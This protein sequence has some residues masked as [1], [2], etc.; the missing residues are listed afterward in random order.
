MLSQPPVAV[1]A[2]WIK[3]TGQTLIAM[4]FVLRFDMF[5]TVN[6]YIWPCQTQEK[7][8]K[9]VWRDDEWSFHLTRLMWYRNTII[10][11]KATSNNS[12]AE[13]YCTILCWGGVPSEC[14][15]AEITTI[16]DPLH[17]TMRYENTNSKC[18]LNIR[19][20]E[21]FRTGRKHIALKIGHRSG[22][23]R[24]TPS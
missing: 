9:T 19:C 4:N 3:S 6:F 18:H 22:L 8:P 24:I 10:I 11:A 17:S 16:K 2:S 21:C 20:M 13:C 12:C 15:I 14:L 23:N 5:S 1:K 7:S